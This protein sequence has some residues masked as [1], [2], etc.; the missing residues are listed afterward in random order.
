MKLFQKLL[1]APAALGLM[2]P[3]AASAADLNIAG[4]SQYGSE[5]QVTSITQFSDVQPTDWA[6]QALSNLIERYGCVA[7]YPNGTYRGSRAMTRYE[8]AALL[9]ACLDR[10]TEVTD[11]LKRL[12]K[13]FEK[14]LAVLKGRVDGLEAKVGELE[15]T[16]F[17]TTTK[18]RGEAT[19]DLGAYTY[20]GSAKNGNSGPGLDDD[21]SLLSAM[22]F[23]YDVRLNFD[24]SFTGKDL[25]RTRLRSG[26]YGESAFDGGQYRAT[27][28][29]KSFESGAG[30]NVVD[31][32]RLYYTF[33][34]GNEL[35]ATL[36]ARVRNTEMLAITP[37]AYKSYITD[38]LYGT[39]GTS[40]TYNKETGAGVGLVW[41]QKVKKG[42]PYLAAGVSYVAKNADKGSPDEGGIMTDNSAGS[43]L[44]QLGGA[45]KNWA[46]TG[47]YRYGQCGTNIRSG[48]QYTYD[49]SKAKCD[50]LGDS[51]ATNSF[52]INGYWQ[53]SESGWVPSI[54]AG[55]GITTFTNGYREAINTKNA[56][57]WMVGLQWDD[58]FVKGNSAG[59][60]VGQ[61]PFTT[62]TFDGSTPYD[63]NYAWEWW[64]NYQVT[65]NISV[66][67]AL[68]YLSRPAGQ[69]TPQG[70]TFNAFAG[71]I[72]VGF[73]F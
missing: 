7:G 4:L 27:K 19:F 16:Q 18:L 1:L 17:S 36:G 11:E 28:L 59:M 60:G 50:D 32:D 13:E 58:V 54:S 24:T 25:L 62:S 49:N 15:A 63:G 57:S 43:F 33:P 20:G 3:V 48:T 40:G 9:N 42:N 69:N 10:I 55:W 71:L 46:L 67:P 21:E 38:F 44:A 29:D 70:E 35:K 14:E 47:A 72:Q 65:D 8:A 30:P 61:S 41:K 73:K 53:P 51:A 68:I 22:V 12:M 64:Y 26:N 37:S 2:A 52:A 31:I 23:N 6:Y 5:E 45:G 66:T 39:Y 34:V 56:Q